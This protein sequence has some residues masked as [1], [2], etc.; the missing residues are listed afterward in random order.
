[1]HCFACMHEVDDL[2]DHTTAFRIDDLARRIH[3]DNVAKGFYDA[4]QVNVSEKL[5]L[6]I[7]ELAEI[8]EAQR[9]SNPAS[10]KIPDFSASEEEA[11]DVIIRMLDLCANQKWRV[12][13]AIF[14]KLAYNR[15][16]QHKHGKLF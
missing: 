15:T 5:M 14:A 7:T 3:E 6:V 10:E 13:A 1:M 11:A 12:G 4:L 16:R 8:C 2:S 9:H